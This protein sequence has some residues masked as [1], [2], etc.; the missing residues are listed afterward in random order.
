LNN[1]NH[2][3]NPETL[4]ERLSP[5]V[6]NVRRSC[7]DLAYSPYCAVK[8]D[9]S[10]AR[11]VI[12][13]IDY[14]ELKKKS[15]HMEVPLFFHDEKAEINF[16]VV[17]HLLNFGH[18]YRHP[19]HNLHNAGAWQTMKHGVE[20]L[21]KRS[22]GVITAESLI[23]LSQEHV[24]EAF[25]LG[26]RTRESDTPAKTTKDLEPLV[27]MI[28]AV[29]RD[30]GRRLLAL[31]LPDFASFVYT[32]S[33]HP[34]NGEPSATWLVHQ[35]ATHFPAFNDR[36]SWRNGREVLFLKK[37]QIAVAELYQRFRDQNPTLF[38]FPDKDRFTVIC[39]NV[40]PCVLR[41]LGVLVLPESLI[42]KI[43]LRQP[44]PAGPEEAELR[45][46]AITA[47]EIMIDNGKGA[48]WAKEIGDYLWALGK[49]PRYRSVERHATLDTCFY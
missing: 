11:E 3:L 21:Q 45:A 42:R 48:F 23:K 16:H 41:T 22:N 40:L 4:P 13:E 35:M 37:A 2:E 31:G 38:D 9:A 43:D 34:E 32:H 30:S 36:R 5:T 47:V 20:E 7:R 17:L 1:L 28:V 15:H 12:G 46:T 26:M 29:A 44:L 10:R 25:D 18:G 14:R 49:D 27:D 19:L 24:I 6:E 8:I 33:R 39:D